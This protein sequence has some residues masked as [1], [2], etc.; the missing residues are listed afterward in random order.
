[1]NISE[2]IPAT[3]CLETGH[4]LMK[5]MLI[6]L[7]ECMDQGEIQALLKDDTHKFTGLAKDKLK[8]LAWWAAARN[9]GT[10]PDGSPQKTSDLQWY[11]NEP[12]PF[13]I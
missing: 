9:L 10:G 2:A 6:M 1:M 12:Y 8:K 5:Q 13:H 4:Q 3:S 7:W 11:R